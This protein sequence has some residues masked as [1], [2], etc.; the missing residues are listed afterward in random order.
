MVLPTAGKKYGKRCYRSQSRY[1]P[2]AHGACHSGAGS[3]PATP[4]GADIHLQPMNDHTLEHMSV[5][6]RHG[7]PMEISHQSRFS[8]RTWESSKDPHWNSL[9][10]KDSTPRKE[11][12]LAWFMK[13]STL[14]EAFTLAKFVGNCLPWVGCHQG[15]DLKSKKQKKK[16]HVII[17][18]IPSPCQSAQGRGRR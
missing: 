14:W 1:S 6:R 12:L 18:P 13:S 8:Y 2:A 4:A 3:S 7:D 16:C 11:L 17:T 10:L 9:F 5:P 15:K